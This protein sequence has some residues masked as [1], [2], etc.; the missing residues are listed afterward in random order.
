MGDPR[1]RARVDGA[2]GAQPPRDPRAR[3]FRGVAHGLRRL[4]RSLRVRHRPR[5]RRAG[6]RCCP[7]SRRCSPRTVPRP[8]RCTANAC[9]RSPPN[10]PSIRHWCSRPSER[11]AREYSP[12]S[13]PTAWPRPS[14]AVRLEADLR[15]DRQGS[16][17]TVPLTETPDGTVELDGLE[18]RFKDEYARRFGEGAIAMGVPVELM[19]LRAICSAAEDRVTGRGPSTPAAGGADALAAVPAAPGRCSSTATPARPTSRCTTA[20]NSIPGWCSSVPRSSTASTPLFGCS[21]ATRPGS[22]RAVRSCSLPPAR[23]KVPRDDRRRPD[24]ARGDAAAGSSPWLM[25]A[26]S[27]SSAPR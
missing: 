22:T 26:R 12:T 18:A 17:L 5:H 4:W 11:C 6:A 9:S 16:E 2:R 3:G 1:G 8:R 20:T 27:P 25:R 24:C 13:R 15:F 19:T 10:C 23:R 7:T 21:G 14:V